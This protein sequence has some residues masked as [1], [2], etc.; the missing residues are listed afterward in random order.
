MGIFGNQSKTVKT[1]I[2]PIKNSLKN[3]FYRKIAL[4]RPPLKSDFRKIWGEKFS[5]IRIRIFYPDSIFSG[6]SGFFWIFLF[7]ILFTCIVVKYI[8]E[9][10]PIW[11]NEGFHYITCPL[12]DAD[13]NYLSKRH[14]ESFYLCTFHTFTFLWCWHYSFGVLWIIQQLNRNSFY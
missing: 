4:Q 2:Q 11:F 7:E 14:I 9:T 5:G 6:F 12:C 3:S 8:R 13:R 10:W 1:V